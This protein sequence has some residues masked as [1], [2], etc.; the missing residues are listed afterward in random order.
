MYIEKVTHLVE[1]A[2]TKGEIRTGKDCRLVTLCFIADYFL[3]LLDLFIKGKSNDPEE[4]L[5]FLRKLID[6]TI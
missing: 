2:Q 3:V 1:A 4:M 5:S 6:Q